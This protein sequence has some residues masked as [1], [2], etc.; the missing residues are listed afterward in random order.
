MLNILKFSITSL[1]FEPSLVCCW[2]A[3]NTLLVRVQEEDALADTPEQRAAELRAAGVALGNAVCK[4]LS[5]P[6]QGEVAERLERQIAYPRKSG[7]AGMLPV[8]PLLLKAAEMPNDAFCCALAEKA[9]WR[10]KSEARDRRLASG[11]G[12]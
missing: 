11:F 7:L 1:A 10:P 5:H 6:V 2:I 4:S 8:L 3:T 12:K 9:F